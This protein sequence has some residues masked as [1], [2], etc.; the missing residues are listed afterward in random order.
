MKFLRIVAA[1][2]T[3]LAIATAGVAMDISPAQALVTCDD[4]YLQEFV[5]WSGYNQ[6]WQLGYYG[7][8]DYYYELWELDGANIVASGC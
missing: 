6:N 1:S 4:L 3:G 8:A 2:L 7:L 5:H